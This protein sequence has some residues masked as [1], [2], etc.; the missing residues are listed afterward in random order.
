MLRFNLEMMRDNRFGIG[1]A[2]REDLAVERAR[3]LAALQD[4]AP[5]VPAIDGPAVALDAMRTMGTSRRI[6]ARVTAVHHHTECLPEE[7]N[8]RREKGKQFFP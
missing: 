4:E 1:I 2:D 6:R 3:S 8:K 5:S 7:M